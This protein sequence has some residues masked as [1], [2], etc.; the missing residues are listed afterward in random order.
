MSLTGKINIRVC[1]YLFPAMDLDYPG[2]NGR[3]NTRCGML[4]GLNADKMVRFFMQSCGCPDND[5]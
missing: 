5:I 2:N 1:I 4:F 3:G